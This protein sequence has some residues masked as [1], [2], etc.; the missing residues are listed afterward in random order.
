MKPC[1]HASRDRPETTKAASVRPH[2]LNR[3]HEDDTCVSTPSHGRPRNR[4][5]NAGV[6][7]H[8]SF[9]DARQWRSLTGWLGGRHHGRAPSTCRA[10]AIRATFRTERTWRRW[11][12]TASVHRQVTRR[13]TSSAIPRRRGRAQGPRA[14]FPSHVRSLTL[15]ET[16]A[17]SA[18]SRRRSRT[19]PA[20][21]SGGAFSARR[22]RWP[23]ETRGTATRQVIDYWNGAGAWD[24]TSFRLRQALAEQIGRAH[25]DYAARAVGRASTGTIS[26]ASSARS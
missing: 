15:I 26:P 21:A 14:T 4:R 24:R 2:K 22:W 19:W 1:G 18:P 7:L 6:L 5:R 13:S 8:G 3:G 16:A 23:R 12:N 9:S 11:S 10:M 17:S 25:R 20:V